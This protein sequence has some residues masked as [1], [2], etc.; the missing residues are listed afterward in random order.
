MDPDD[1]DFCAD[2]LEKLTDEF[3]KFPDTQSQAIAIAL[4]FTHAQSLVLD[5]AAR[6]RSGA[7]LPGAL[8][9]VVVGDF[10]ITKAAAETIKSAASP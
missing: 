8:N 5:C 4:I 10:Q 1:L 6:L 2:V 7:D 3:I 9:A